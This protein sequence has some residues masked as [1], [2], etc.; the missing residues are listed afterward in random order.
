MISLQTYNIMPG[1]I[2][3]VNC[4]DMAFPPRFCTNIGKKI[5]A[6]KDVDMKLLEQVR[7]VCRARHYFPRTKQSIARAFLLNHIVHIH[8]AIA[9]QGSPAEAGSLRRQG[10][11]VQSAGTAG[12]RAGQLCRHH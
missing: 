5:L 11:P 10:T 4:E 9:V 6:W 7:Q 3:L 1:V 2:Y 8:S 12:H